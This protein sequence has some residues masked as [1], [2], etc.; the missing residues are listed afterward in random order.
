MRKFKDKFKHNLQ[1][2]DTAAGQYTSEYEVKI[3]FTMPEFSGSKLIKHKF[4]VDKEDT[5][6]N[7]GYEMIIGCNL[8]A[9][10]VGCITDFKRKVLTWE[11]IS[12]PMRS[13]YTDTDKPQFSRA[14]ISMRSSNKEQNHLRL[15]NELSRFFIVTTRL[16]ISTR[17]YIMQNN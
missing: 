3:N 17:S 16:L 8:Q 10:L 13:A 11:D 4:Q 7:I 5:N 9:K 1:V 14:E 12:V 2:Y 6:A 15:L